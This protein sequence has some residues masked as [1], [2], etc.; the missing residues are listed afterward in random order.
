MSLEIKF[1]PKDHIIELVN[2][3]VYDRL[4]GVEAVIVS[5]GINSKEKPLEALE[6]ADLVGL[7]TP[8]IHRIQNLL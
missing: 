4:K 6:N 8:F 2:K 3:V 7:S 5:G 1:V